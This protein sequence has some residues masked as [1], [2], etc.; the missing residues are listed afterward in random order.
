MPLNKP[1]PRLAILRA[2]L[3]AKAADEAFARALYSYSAQNPRTLRALPPLADSLPLPPSYWD[4]LEHWLKTLA[5]AKPAAPTQQ[6]AQKASTHSVCIK[7][8]K[9]IG[10]NRDIGTVVPMLP[11]HRSRPEYWLP[12]D[13]SGWVTHVPTADAVCPVPDGVRFETRRRDGSIAGDGWNPRNAWELG[14]SHSRE[15]VCGDIIAWRPI[16]Q[17]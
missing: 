12:C 2:Q 1:S 6:P 11:H 10:V 8:H 15:P 3:A 7:A 13:E 9:S 17:S 16:A 5:P 14:H 4:D